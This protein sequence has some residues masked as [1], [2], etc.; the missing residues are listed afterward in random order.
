MDSTDT[1]I[2]G[3]FMGIDG[4]QIDTAYMAARGYSLT[5]EDAL[6]VMKLPMGGPDGYYKVC[7]LDI[8]L[9]HSWPKTNDYSLS[10]SHAVNNQYHIRYNIEAMLELLWSDGGTDTTKY[11]VIFPIKTPLV[12]GL[13]QLVDSE[14][15]KPL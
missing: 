9:F 5:M 7:F 8:L 12:S 10:Q 4:K 14:F 2:L 15:K 13:P 1:K 3:M 6:I 11:K